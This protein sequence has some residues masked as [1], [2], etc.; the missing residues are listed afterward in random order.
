MARVGTL[1]LFLNLEET[2][3]LSPLSMMSAIGLL[4]MEYILLQCFPSIPDLLRVSNVTWCWILSDDFFYIH[5][6]D[7]I[8]FILYS[9]EVVHHIYWFLHFNDPWISGI[10][11]IS[12]LCMILL[13]CC[14]IL[15]ASIWWRI[16]AHMLIR[17]IG[18]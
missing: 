3:N 7:Y 12:L 9:V 5:W 8:I 4:Y 18:L 16:F 13:T 15:F 11:S 1:V 17:D 14:W 10:D 2:F 6:D